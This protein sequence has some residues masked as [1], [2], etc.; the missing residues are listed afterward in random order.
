MGAKPEPEV[1]HKNWISMETL[2]QNFDKLKKT[3]QI[4][5]ELEAKEWTKFEDKDGLYFLN[6]QFHCYTLLYIHEEKKAYIADG[7]NMFRT[8]D[9]IATGIKNLLQIRLILLKPTM[10][11]RS[12]RKFGYSYWN[13]NA[14]DVWSK[15]N[16]SNPQMLKNQRKS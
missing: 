14:Q 9:R 15:D 13:R 5:V 12:L 8:D 4:R 1:N 11:N 6:F 3:L 16:D 7:G 10:G 2:L